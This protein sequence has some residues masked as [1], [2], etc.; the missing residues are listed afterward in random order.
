MI[1]SWQFIAVGISSHALSMNSWLE[2]F[3]DFSIQMLLSVLLLIL[4]S[5]IYIIFGKKQGFKD[6]FQFLKIS[7]ENEDLKDGKVRHLSYV[8]RIVAIYTRATFAISGYF[9]FELA[10]SYISEIDNSTLHGADALIYAIMFGWWIDK[11]NT[12]LRAYTKNQWAGM[13]ISSSAILVTLIYESLIKNFSI[14]IGG[15]AI[16]IGSAIMLSLVI[17]ISSIV[18]YHD[19]V[20]RIAFHNCLFGLIVSCIML[21]LSVVMSHHLNFFE[22]INAIQRLDFKSSALAS[23]TYTFALL[24]FLQSYKYIQ[25]IFI[26]MLGNALGIGVV[27]LT[28]VFHQQDLNYKDIVITILL[29]VGSIILGIDEW[30]KETHEDSNK[31]IG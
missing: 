23:L 19:S 14:A 17:L 16:G 26:A 4:F 7:Q 12:G 31:T 6:I 5:F 22:I 29:S 21:F 30:K 9:L 27:F 2:R 25:P 13:I 18:V 11:K 15:V 10:K 28:L 3:V 24:G 8:Q 1:V 20:I